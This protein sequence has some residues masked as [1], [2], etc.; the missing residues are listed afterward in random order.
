[1][2][3]RKLERV[4]IYLKVWS[5]E[6]ADSKDVWGEGKAKKESRSGAQEMGG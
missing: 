4:R 1:M 3:G 5:I 2:R 6:L